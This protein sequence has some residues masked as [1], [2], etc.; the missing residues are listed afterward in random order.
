MVPTQ[1]PNPI[2]NTMNFITKFTQK[3]SFSKNTKPLGRWNV[4]YCD[5]I[6]NRKIDMANEDHC[7][8]CSEYSAKKLTEPKTTNYIQN[9]LTPQ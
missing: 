9:P 7:G 2:Y 4:D 1:T 5:K 3:F 8:T 6:I